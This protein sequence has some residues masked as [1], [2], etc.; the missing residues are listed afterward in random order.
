[1]IKYEISKRR[2]EVVKFAEQNTAM[3]STIGDYD[4]DPAYGSVWTRNLLKV[5]F[6]AKKSPRGNSVWVEHWSLQTGAD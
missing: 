1:M 3:S 2:V 4:R 6:N 5:F